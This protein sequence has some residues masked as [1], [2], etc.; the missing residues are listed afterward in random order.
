MTT[1]KTF[2]LSR[3]I[4]CRVHSGNKGKSIGTVK[5]I[6]VDAE[7]ISDPEVSVRPRVTGIL[8]KS[9]RELKFIRPSGVTFSKIKKRI[10][11]ECTSVNLLTDEEISNGLLLGDIIMDKQIVDLNGRKLVR[12]NDVRLVGVSDGMFAIAVDVGVEG[13]LRRIGI[14]RQVKALTKLFNLSVPA[15]FILWDDVQALDNNNL[16]IK[17]SKT[18]SKLNTL[19]PSD[20]ADIIEELGQ[21]SRASVFSSL[22]EE[23]AADVLEEL[24]TEAQ[25]NII[26]SLPVEKA[27]D[28][29]EKMPADEAADILDEL[30]DEKAEMLLNEMEAE[31]S[32]EVRELLEY[33]DNTVG[34]IMSTD[35][36]A[37]RSD[38]TVAQVLDEFRATQPEDEALY[39]LFVTTPNDELEASV[40]L[41]DL[42]VSAPNTPLSSIMKETPIILY[43]DQKVY[44]IAEHISKYN[45][46][47]IP[48]VDRE[49]KLQGMVVINDVVE[50]L[51]NERKTNR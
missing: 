1:L 38:T 49:N 35:F 32:Q 46:L 45:L 50:D 41:R 5:D 36:L 16:N 26:E 40:S 25:V 27:A 31:S 42:V 14:A 19:H 28:V 17:L 8:V 48:V 24:E 51:I 47:A 33:E 20:L 37:Y 23:H 44:E 30:E 29:L 18:S 13:L 39:N 22:D 4:G 2:Y 34:S 10:Y 9:G 11:C 43:D 15:K 3:I 7:N 12:V 21:Q 6:L